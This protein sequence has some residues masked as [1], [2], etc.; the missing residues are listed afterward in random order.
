MSSWPKRRGNLGFRLEDLK[1]K[2]W[3]STLAKE[4]HSRRTAT[5]SSRSPRSVVEKQ[6]RQHRLKWY[7]GKGSFLKKKEKKVFSPSG[8]YSPKTEWKCKMEEEEYNRISVYSSM[9]SIDV[10][11]Y[12]SL[13]DELGCCT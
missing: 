8:I 13:R 6:G 10:K 2:E 11:V 12:K 7:C 5:G 9:E 4:S 1:K 3:S